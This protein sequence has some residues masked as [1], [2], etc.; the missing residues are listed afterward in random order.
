MAVRSLLR[1]AENPTGF[2]IDQMNALA[3]S[4]CHGDERRIVHCMVLG[5]SVTVHSGD[6]AAKH[7]SSHFIA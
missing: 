5:C 2:R 3:S 1:R 6:R 7:K 4:A